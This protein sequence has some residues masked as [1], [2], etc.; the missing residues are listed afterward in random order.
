M[1]SAPASS[2]VALFTFLSNRNEP[3][4]TSFSE[5]PLLPAHVE[6]APG[7]LMNVL[8]AP[9]YADRVLRRPAMVESGVGASLSSSDCR[10]I[11][12]LQTIG[13]AFLDDSYSFKFP[14][15]QTPIR[16][17]SPLSTQPLRTTARVLLPNGP[18]KLSELLTESNLPP[19]FCST[20]GVEVFSPSATL[21]VLT[22]EGT[23]LDWS[24]V[25]PAEADVLLHYFETAELSDNQ[26]DT[27]RMLP[28]FELEPPGDELVG[29]CV[30]LSSIVA[31]REL[32]SDL[33]AGVGRECFLRSKATVAPKLYLRLGIVPM[34]VA[35]L[36]QYH[37]FPL[38]QDMDDTMRFKH[39][40]AVAR[41]LAS[42]NT[43]DY[44][45]L[46]AAAR[47]LAWVRVADGSLVAAR[48]TLDPS[49]L[50]FRHFFHE[51]LPVEVGDSRSWQLPLLR[52]LG[53]R[54]EFDSQTFL[55]CSR[56]A[57]AEQS[58]DKA[59]A[60]LR[61]LASDWESFQRELATSEARKEFWRELGSLALAPVSAAPF[62][63]FSA[64]AA[65]LVPLPSVA[66]PLR[67][68]GYDTSRRQVRDGLL[69]FTQR[70][71]L[72]DVAYF[73]RGLRDALGME[74]PSLA[75]VLRHLEQIT[76]RGPTPFEH[77]LRQSSS[78]SA[79]TVAS[80][81]TSRISFTLE[82]TMD[83]I[84]TFL[85]DHCTSGGEA[86]VALAEKASTSRPILVR[87]LGVG[88]ARFVQGSA[89]F[90]ELP[91]ND[92]S[93]YAFHLSGV[94]ASL[95]RHPR[96]SVLLELLG[97]KKEPSAAD[98]L[99]WLDDV[100][101]NEGVYRN[102]AR[103][104]SEAG[105]VL[106]DK[107]LRLLSKLQITDE[108]LSNLLLPDVNRVLYPARRL[109]LNDAPWLSQ[110]IDSSKLRICHPRISDIALLLGADTV[111]Q[112]FLAC[113]LSAHGWQRP[114][115]PNIGPP[116]YLQHAVFS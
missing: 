88:A 73:T 71:V 110:R 30:A 2:P 41:N 55:E 10:V 31:P 97:V 113:F 1:R 15:G 14:I 11:R 20:S 63:A 58:R 69:L 78:F 103:T 116:L 21:R 52:L 66:L 98:I 19:S 18:L 90:R 64:A 94:P 34:S 9:R 62:G 37:V 57:A 17:C 56:L 36:Y 33:P 80:Q 50:V 81:I 114:S 87:E 8:V 16:L 99:R 79:T 102:D 24:K 5:W 89:V 76:E 109:V 106:T 4:S 70:P 46:L 51:R 35:E 48:D 92:L 111:S 54:S 67:V 53:C 84:Y 77:D 60:L 100:A 38:F 32:P 40:C 22:D 108:V 85:A 74:P 93:P 65:K 83:E 104:L 26:L 112:V 44:D 115:P 23:N 68:E 72:E 47:P 39:M 82:Q 12:L 6:E 3:I 75:E 13:V 101:A 96:A 91:T 49:N 27:V 29:R 7:S 25:G 42:A 59:S 105:L 28:V 86:A 45:A 107:M 43:A 95:Q 61:H